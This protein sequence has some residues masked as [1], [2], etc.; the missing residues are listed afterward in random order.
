MDAVPNS[1]LYANDTA[2]EIYNVLKILLSRKHAGS[3][4]ASY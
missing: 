4:N 3:V 2:R 1:I